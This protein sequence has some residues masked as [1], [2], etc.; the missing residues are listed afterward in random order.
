MEDSLALLRFNCPDVACPAICLGWADLKRHVVS[1]H[2]TAL[3]DLCCVNK[4]IFTHEHTLFAPAELKAHVG[5]E[6]TQC[7]FCRITFYDSEQL[8][9]HCRDKHEECFICVRQGIRHQ[10]HRNYDRLVRPSQTPQLTPANPLGRPQEAHYKSDHFL[11]PHPTCLEQKFVVFE[12]E[13]DLQAHAVATHG[14]ALSGDQRARHNARRIE[15]H[16]TYEG[17]GGG[18]SGGG[19]RGG[20]G[21]G[22]GR[23]REEAAPVAAFVH[24]VEAAPARNRVVP[25]LAPAQPS[26]SG[27]RDAPPHRAGRAAPV[28][29]AAPARAIAPA[30]AVAP[31]KDSSTVE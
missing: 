19:G 31:A 17:E 27:A 10:Y 3:C 25:G 28:P 11:C 24:S 9:R 20:R 13:L 26:G 14:A 29:A 12:T 8:Y 7:E 15:T 6:H 16:F 23:R 21:G 1:E 2:R 18:S 4:K 22:G 5:E 30:K